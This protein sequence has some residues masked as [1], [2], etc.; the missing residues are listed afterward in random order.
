MKFLLILLLPVLGFRILTAE[1][2]ERAS[3]WS[4]AG[5]FTL[6]E[7]VPGV[8]EIRGKSGFP[9]LKD[10][11]G[12]RV[13]AAGGKA[14]A[15][16]VVAWSHG[17]F[18]RG[19]GLKQKAALEVFCNS[20]KWAGDQS[21]PKV[22][23][24]SST[25]AVAGYLEPFGLQMERVAPEDLA[26]ER[27]DVYCLVPDDRDL[28]RD[29]IDN[30]IAYIESGGGVVVATTPWAFATRY[31]DFSQSPGNR[32]LGAAGLYY[33][34]R[35]YASNKQ[36]VYVARP[37]ESIPPEERNWGDNPKS[38]HPA[39]EAVRLLTKNKY[40]NDLKK[41]A[42]LI[43]DL[44]LGKTLGGEDVAA[45]LKALQLLNGSM[46]GIRPTR[47][48]PVRP[49]KFPIVDAI[50]E[51]ET[52]FN[53]TLP[54]GMMYS[55]PASND[56]PGKVPG[57][58]PRIKKQLEINCD[59]KGW[60]QHRIPGAWN[61]KEIRSTGVYA[62]PGE[63]IKVIVPEAI[64]ACGYEVLIGSYGGGLDNHNV[65]HR[66][67]RTQKARSIR[68]TETEISNGFGG[69]VGIR[70]PQDA[71]AGMQTI[72]ISGGVAAPLYVH[73]E[74]DLDDWR[75]TIRNHPGP[76]AELGSERIIITV[77][78]EHI[79]YLDNPDEVMELWN[80]VI[81]MSA[82]L[83][84][85]DRDEY[86]AE[87][88]VFDRQPSAGLLH[89]GYPVCGHTGVH[90]ELAVNAEKLRK[91][92]FW[93]FFHE[94]GHNHQHALWALPGT[95]ETTCN[96]WS[97][98]IYEEL[99][100]KSREEAHRALSP[101]VRLQTRRRYF[102]TGADFD[103][104]WNMWTALDTFLL[105]QEEFGWEPYRKI[106]A[107]YHEMPKNEWPKTQQEINDQLVVRL[108]IACGRNLAPYWKIWNLPL[109]DKVE[110][111]LKVLPVWQPKEVAKWSK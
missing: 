7:S 31:I 76:W 70:I 98:Y 72:Y 47:K 83:A 11:N 101:L 87:R 64:A 71:S 12:E 111:V 14:G 30:I 74:T 22:G 43:A 65:W 6:G 21:S 66:Y 33:H 77:P 40:T 75:K 79:R 109:T 90:S 102:E 88:L 61:A 57:Y 58:A 73:G 110:Q 37:L 1:S 15:G 85:L 105:I 5:S 89:S 46:G 67:P 29:D 19:A 84:T 81:E 25:V 48:Q 99:I 93:G 34:P 96:F 100:G 45:Y 9:I 4:G 38:N 18:L 107:E 35:A 56:F 97:I 20:L 55:I 92:G 49:G 68:D 94:Y 32:I 26:T 53:L 36:P 52:H 54:A 13:F 16:R 2:L 8:I 50:I 63:V 10:G 24:H 62:A 91:D 104:N 42:K 103:K 106:F 39:V 82:D 59:Y 3:I 27:P 95:L 17:S 23:L 78:A 108:S 60:A 86:R 28:D 80:T 44:K 51:M 69:L 41:Q